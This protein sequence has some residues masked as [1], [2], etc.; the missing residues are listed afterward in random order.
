MS[1]GS[2]ELIADRDN[3]Y[4]FI[5]FIENYIAK[6]G[7]QKEDA[8]NILLASEE[9]IINIISYAYENEKGTIKIDLSNDKGRINLNFTDYGKP[10]NPLKINETDISLPL[11]KRGEGGYGI[12]IVKK[13]MDSVHYEYRDGKNVLTV[14]KHINN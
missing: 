2:L 9:I 8:T 1:P 7:I 11:E 12:L 5:N 13:I 6:I 14:T 10:F 3:F 4:Q